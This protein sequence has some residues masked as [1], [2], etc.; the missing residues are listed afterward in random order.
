MFL[1]LKGVET[2]FDGK[3]SIFGAR[4]NLKGLTKTISIKTRN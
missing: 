2:I 4:V 1:G 3:T